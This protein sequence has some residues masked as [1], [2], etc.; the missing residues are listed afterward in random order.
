LESR[1]LSYSVGLGLTNECN[2]SC[3][4]CY[5]PGG[6][7]QR[8]T[9]ADVD[10]I[11]DS[12]P[13]H[14]V[15]LGTGENGLHPDFE[16]ILKSL[17]AR[18]LKVSLTSN[19]YTLLR[20]SDELLR[21]LHDVEVSIDFPTEERQDAFRGAGSFATVTSAISRCRAL[22]LPVTVIAVMMNTNYLEL[23][24]I[25]R[26]A[27]RLG[28]RFRF[29]V[30]QPVNTDR[31]SLDYDQFWE[32]FRSIL[33]QTYLVSCTEPLVAAVLG[34]KT[35]HGSPCGGTSLRLTPSKRVMPC[36]YWPD[37]TLSLGELRAAGT[38]VVDSEP[39]RLSRTVPDACAA[40]ELVAICRGGC[41]SRRAISDA[42]DEPDPFCPIVRGTWPELPVRRREGAA[43]VE[44][45]HAKNYC[46]TIVEA[47]P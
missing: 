21:R 40:C 43:A 11:C 26:L 45:L 23:A 3:G 7:V 35:V 46:T 1:H 36:V 32:G 9:L 14:S 10:A 38:A 37:G 27:A 22:G 13:V 12:V 30:Y 44:L 4:H 25:A 19:G 24:D 31:Y 34:L 29:N 16:E 18:G 6:D 42:I 20:M 47:L 39:F 5:R 8:L 33:S 28:A 2:L 15:N 17:L 41:A